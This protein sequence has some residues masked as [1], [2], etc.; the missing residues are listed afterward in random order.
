MGY[1]GIG[2]NR[3]G[4]PAK[5]HC[6][7]PAKLDDGKK[8]KAYKG[9]G[10]QGDA[11]MTDRQR[12]VDQGSVVR[13]KDY[14]PG[15]AGQEAFNKDRRA[16]YDNRQTQK[17]EIKQKRKSGEFSAKEAQAAKQAQAKRMQKDAS[18]KT[19]KADRNKG[20]KP[21]TFVVSRKGVKRKVSSAERTSYNTAAKKTASPAKQS[22][23]GFNKN[24]KAAKNAA[25]RR[26]TKTSIPPSLGGS[27]TKAAIDLVK[28]GV[29]NQ[30]DVFG[31][32]GYGMP[33][34]KSTKTAKKK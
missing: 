31:R 18:L 30:K 22:V 28:K 20:D 7:S 12:R 17:A 25:A 5:M 14:A 34:L 4:S 10:A 13:R 24:S 15:R 1:K 2:P 33:R 23:P 21:T 27:A 11:Q 16:A 8:R 9:G 19:S 6:T 3:L 26:K 32:A 29:K